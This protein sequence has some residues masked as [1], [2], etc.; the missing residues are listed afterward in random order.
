MANVEPIHTSRNCLTPSGQRG[1]F[2]DFASQHDLIQPSNV[3]PSNFH[4]R[5]QMIAAKTFPH[6]YFNDRP[7]RWIFGNYA[8]HNLM[9]SND[10]PHPNSTWPQSREVIARDL[11]HVSEETR[12]RLLRENVRGLYQLP[13][14]TSLLA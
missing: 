3:L 7:A 14:L 8:S 5:Q 1:K 4:E 11:G 10:Y 6:A 2:S 12:A 9:W 13:A